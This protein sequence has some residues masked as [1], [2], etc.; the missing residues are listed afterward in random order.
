MSGPDIE[1]PGRDEPTEIPPPAG[2]P[3]SD[4]DRYIAD[5]AHREHA[6]HDTDP[7]LPG[8]SH[9]WWIE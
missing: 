7:V 2:E 5:R 1:W 9:G 3:L 6:E 8:H 4:Y